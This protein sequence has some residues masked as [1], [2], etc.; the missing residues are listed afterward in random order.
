MIKKGYF[1][2]KIYK[3]YN[4]I[5]DIII[6]KGCVYDGEK[7]DFEFKNGIIYFKETNISKSVEITL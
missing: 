3:T 7:I 4:G 1:I 2:V 6:M 5:G